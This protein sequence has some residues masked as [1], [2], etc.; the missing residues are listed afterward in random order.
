MLCHTGWHAM[1]RQLGRQPP[2]CTVMAST[3]LLPASLSHHLGAA[4]LHTF[5]LLSHHP[6][7]ASCCSA[8][9]LHHLAAAPLHP[10]ALQQQ[11]PQGILIPSDRLGHNSEPGGMLGGGGLQSVTPLQGLNSNTVQLLPGGGTM[12]L[13]ASLALQLQQ[14]RTSIGGH[15]GLP[16]QGGQDGGA[17]NLVNLVNSQIATQL[18]GGASVQGLRGVLAAAGGTQGMGAGL[19]HHAVGGSGGSGLGQ[20]MYG[21]GD[22]TTPTLGMRRPPGLADGNGRADGRGRGGSGDVD[23]GGSG[24]GASKRGRR[25]AAKSS[26]SGGE[27]DL[28][29]SPSAAIAEAKRAMAEGRMTF[30]DFGLDVEALERVS[31]DGVGAAGVGRG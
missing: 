18:G 8:S 2:A 21:A 22:V 5:A 6:A 29:R 3:L 1:L 17:S 19:P 13:P 28:P 15:M 26:N 9:L 4:S 14:G 12:A 27:D 24:R 11:Q 16:G 20:D 30:A 25:E 23:R 7:V 31:V 10:S